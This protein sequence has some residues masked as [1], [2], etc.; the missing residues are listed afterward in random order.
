[1]NLAPPGRNGR[2][3]CGVLNRPICLHVEAPCVLAA[4]SVAPVDEAHSETSSGAESEP[5]A[6]ADAGHG[7]R[8]CRE[9]GAQHSEGVPVVVERLLVDQLELATEPRDV[10]QQLGDRRREAEIDERLCR[11]AVADSERSI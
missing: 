5:R 11:P 3:R 2:A 4:P 10:T 1:M 7:E 9:R 8:A 6:A